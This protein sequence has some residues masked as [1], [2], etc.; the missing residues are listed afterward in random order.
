MGNKETLLVSAIVDTLTKVFKNKNV[1]AENKRKSI[2]P[3]QG[4]VTDSILK[5]SWNPSG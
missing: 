4:N 5:W 1:K 2:K 3:L